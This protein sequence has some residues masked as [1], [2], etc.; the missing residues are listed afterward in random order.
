VQKL[1]TLRASSLV[2]KRILPCSSISRREIP[3]KGSWIGEI[4]EKAISK[5]FFF[6][7]LD[8]L[9]RDSK[10]KFLQG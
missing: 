6:G 8:D 10:L 3:A 1:V 9:I 7:F 5:R 4:F 2:P